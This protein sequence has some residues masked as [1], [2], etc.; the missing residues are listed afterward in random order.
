MKYYQD[1]EMIEGMS[2]DDEFAGGG[3]PLTGAV[4][5]GSVTYDGILTANACS[6]TTAIVDPVGLYL[7][8]IG[9]V[10]LLTPD[11]EVAL[12]KYVEAGVAALQRLND[13]LAPG[14]RSELGK[15]V[16]DGLAARD[17][18]VC[19]NS[20]LVVSIARKY[21]GYGVPFLDLIQEGNIGLIRA[22]NK[23]DYRLGHK[24]STYA[25][26]WIRQAITRAIADQGRTIRVPV[27][28]GDQ[29]NRMLW[30]AHRLTQDLGR[31]PTSEELAAALGISTRKAEEMLIVATPL[32]SMETPTGED[33]DAELGEFI[34]DESISGPDE[35]VASGMLRTLLNE[36]LQGFP[37]RE[38]HILQ[39]RYGLADGK[40]HTLEEVGSKLGVTRERVRQIEARALRRL[41]HPAYSRRLRDFLA[42]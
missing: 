30:I 16:L 21:V 26:W 10:P 8:E 33:G 18:L 19:A 42:K 3:S 15:A 35:E 17:H 7:K 31:E 5:Q 34:E 14:E 25:T 22:T 39:L 36:I 32:L 29:I 12:A 9:R 41:R 27:Y 11:Q 23:F 20:R 37:S 6:D 24:F 40:M 4:E 38:A 1:N 13:N 28:L 2:T